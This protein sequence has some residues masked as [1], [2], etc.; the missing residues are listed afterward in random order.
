MQLHLNIDPRTHKLKYQWAGY[1]DKRRGRKYFEWRPRNW[2]LQ[3]RMAFYW[4][5]FRSN[6]GREP[7][8]IALDYGPSILSR[9]ETIWH[10]RPPPAATLPR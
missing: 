2:T 6:A 9:D 10:L 3:S 4:V 5:V 1:P 8:L 7:L